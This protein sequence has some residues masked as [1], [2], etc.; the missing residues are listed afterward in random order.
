MCSSPALPIQRDRSDG[1]PD[2][3][4]DIQLL[5]RVH[6]PAVLTEN[7]FMTNEEDLRFLES[8]AGRQAIVDLHV[9]GICEYLK[10]A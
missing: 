9:E 7:G 1:D 10:V 8:P 5:T 4:E 2:F 3:E 6:C